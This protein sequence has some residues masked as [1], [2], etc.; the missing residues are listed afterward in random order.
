MA[1]KEGEVMKYLLKP[2]DNK[3]V[4]DEIDLLFK[5]YEAKMFYEGNCISAS[6]KNEF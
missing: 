5:I 6:A 1:L 2:I 3:N 4:R